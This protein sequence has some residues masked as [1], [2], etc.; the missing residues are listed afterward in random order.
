[1][2]PVCG[3]E[4]RLNEIEG[5]VVEKAIQGCDRAAVHRHEKEPEPA[6]IESEPAHLFVKRDE[7]GPVEGVRAAATTLPAHVVQ[8]DEPCQ[9]RL[10]LG[11][12][13][14]LL[15]AQL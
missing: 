8:R 2:L 9:R 10:S 11:R 1:M 7:I 5:A 4:P 12:R 3:V 13:A 6:P 15:E 14:R